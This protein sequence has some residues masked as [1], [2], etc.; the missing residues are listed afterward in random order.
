V[1]VLKGLWA[2]LLVVSGGVPST[3]L[4]LFIAG[5]VLDAGLILV[6]VVFVLLGLIEGLLLAEKLGLIFL[7]GLFPRW[8]EILELV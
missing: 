1:G 5:L 3:G 6:G 7:P 2:W 8:L 4:S